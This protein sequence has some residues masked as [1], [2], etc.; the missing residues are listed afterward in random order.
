MPT[1]TAA[2]MPAPRLALPAIA[3][4][5][6]PRAAPRKGPVVELA[7][8][9]AHDQFVAAFGA[10]DR[11]PLY[12]RVF[13]ELYKFLLQER[14]RRTSGGFEIDWQAPRARCH[15]HILKASFVPSIEAIRRSA[16][17]CSFW[18]SLRPARSTQSCY[19]APRFWDLPPSL[20]TLAIN[21]R[22]PFING[23]NDTLWGH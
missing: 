14:T 15:W 18:P 3:P 13:I 23:R 21:A 16:F 12:Y 7:S 4:P 8:A 6:A 20:L 17:A 1:P 5:A 2:P 11:Q 22:S 9:R 19:L 10:D